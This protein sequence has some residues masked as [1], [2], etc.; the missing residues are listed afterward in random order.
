[1]TFSRPLFMMAQLPF[2][3]DESVELNTPMTEMMNDEGNIRVARANLEKLGIHGDI[4]APSTRF[5]EIGCGRGYL[6]ENLWEKGRGIYCGVEPIPS[7]YRQAAARLRPF[8]TRRG[9][10]ISHVVK[11]SLLENLRFESKYFN[12]I[13]SYHVFEHLENPLLM[14]EKAGE[15]LGPE[16]RLIITCPNVEGWIPRRDLEKWRCS[17]PSHRWLPGRSTL[18]RAL[19]ESGYEVEKWFT[20]GGYP[21]PRTKLQEGMNYI[22][23]W[24]GMGDVICLMAVRR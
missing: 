18:L 7:Q 5:L 20:Y 3:R 24:F 12:Y 19:E 16:G 23:K 10:K 8:V 2:N 1:M 21:A 15:W 17:I 9:E 11:A 22:L 6:L 4:L 14:L 13:Y